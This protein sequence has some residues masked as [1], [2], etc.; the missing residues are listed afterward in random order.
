MWFH[1]SHYEYRGSLLFDSLDYI[2]IACYLN[3][4][5]AS[6]SAPKTPLAIILCSIVVLLVLN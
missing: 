4:F 3:S 1:L 2:T 5:H 6:F